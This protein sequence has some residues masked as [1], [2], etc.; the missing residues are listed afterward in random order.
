MMTSNAMKVAQKR[1]GVSQDGTYGPKTRGAGFLF[2]G[3]TIQHPQRICGAA[4]F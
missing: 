1:L 4:G 2:W 3:V